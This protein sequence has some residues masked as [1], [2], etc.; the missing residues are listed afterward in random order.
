MKSKNGM[1][2]KMV[3]AGEVGGVL[4]IILQRLADFMEKAERLKRRIKGALIYPA[5]VITI[6]VLIVTGIMYFVILMLS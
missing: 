1:E 2:P 6:A 3:A 4:D 5:V